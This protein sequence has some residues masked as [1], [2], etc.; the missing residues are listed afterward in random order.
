MEHD[1]RGH[2]RPYQM[3]LVR[4][5]DR[6]AQAG[7]PDDVRYLRRFRTIYRHLA[8]SVIGVSIEAGSAMPTGMPGI[9]SPHATEILEKTEKE[10]DNLA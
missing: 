1:D 6:L 8:A 3:E 7:E 5:A 4:I 9:P 2:V 10:L